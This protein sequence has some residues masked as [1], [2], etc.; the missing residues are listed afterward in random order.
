MLTNNQSIVLVL[1][2]HLP[3]LSNDCLCYS[4]VL[5]MRLEHWQTNKTNVWLGIFSQVQNHS[6][7]WGITPLYFGRLSFI[8]W[9]KWRHNLGRNGFTVIFCH[10]SLFQNIH[11]QTQLFKLII[12]IMS[13]NN[14]VW[15]WMFWNKLGWQNIT[16]KPFLPR[17]WRHLGQM[18]KESLPK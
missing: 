13:L 4:F 12:M 5:Y 18:M 2:I 1:F 9:P 11:N 14:W 6:N 15:L 10:P 7:H 3:I 17:L 16:V 8:I